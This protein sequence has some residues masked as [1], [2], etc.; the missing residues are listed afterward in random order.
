MFADHHTLNSGN[1]RATLSLEFNEVD[2]L[3]HL[4]SLLEIPG[5]HSDNLGVSI[6]VIKMTKVVYYHTIALF[7]LV[8][9]VYI[10]I[11]IYVD[12]YVY[13]L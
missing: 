10:Y 11:N 8:S 13:I 5:R 2:P 4:K 6:T 9:F 12:L 7:L 3:S 1:G